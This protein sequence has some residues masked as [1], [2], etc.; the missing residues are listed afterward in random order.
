MA[1]PEIIYVDASQQQ[2]V[3][4]MNGDVVVGTAEG[5]NIRFPASSEGVDDK[6]LHFFCEEKTE[7]YYVKNIGKQIVF[8]N[9]TTLQPGQRVILGY[10]AFFIFGDKGDRAR[11]SVLVFVDQSR[12]EQEEVKTRSLKQKSEKDRVLDTEVESFVRSFYAGLQNI[13]PGLEQ[14]AK[15]FTRFIFDKFPCSTVVLYRKTGLAWE[16][17]GSMRANRQEIYRPSL[18]L[19]YKAVETG[20]PIFFKVEPGG[21]EVGNDLFEA[22]NSVIESGARR[23]I[24]IPLV[25]GSECFGML[26]LDGKDTELLTE[27]EFNKLSRALLEGGMLGTVSGHLTENPEMLRYI[28]A[29]KSYLLKEWP[30]YFG[31]GNRH[32]HYPLVSFRGSNAHGKARL[33]YGICGNDLSVVARARAFIEGLQAADIHYA[34][35]REVLKDAVEYVEN[36]TAEDQRQTT[37]RLADIRIIFPF[38]ELS[39][40]GIE[41]EDDDAAVVKKRPESL[42]TI[43]L[44]EDSVGDYTIEVRA[45]AG[46]NIYLRIGNEI[47]EILKGGSVSSQQVA[48]GDFVVV[49]PN[50]IP[51][52]VLKAL[53]NIRVRTQM[54]DKLKRSVNDFAL[55]TRER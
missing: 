38:Q 6:H 20:T 27:H 23:V 28:A 29:T 11:A 46:M 31:V 39:T 1:V 18:S 52:Y 12:E 13:K 49:T 36:M 43:K 24:M 3:V 14:V 34:V 17:V 48:I 2:Q 41:D 51:S 25:L 16:T 42:R 21:V 55:L 53:C 7:R 47:K 50:T 8:A 44:S 40:E 35:F 15:Y 33:I 9:N 45:T 30:W 19:F 4:E 10:K 54:L 5:C 22:S 26:Y 32:V 37:P